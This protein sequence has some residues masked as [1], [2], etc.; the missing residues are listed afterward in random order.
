MLFRSPF[1]RVRYSEAGVVD[2]TTQYSAGLLVRLAPLPAS[3]EAA[4]ASN[5]NGCCMKRLIDDVVGAY[6]I[7]LSGNGQRH[8]A[9]LDHRLQ[10]PD[11]VPAGWSSHGHRLQPAGAQRHHRRGHVGTATSPNSPPQRRLL[12]RLQH[13]RLL[14]FSLGPLTST[15]EVANSVINC[16]ARC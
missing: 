1:F 4:R 14:F 12:L 6:P 15:G 10:Q 16:P 7:G 5:C 8:H 3:R 2:S 9:Q 13:Y 11:P